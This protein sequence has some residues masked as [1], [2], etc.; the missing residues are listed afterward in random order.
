ME[1]TAALPV[2][3]LLDY[4]SCVV[5]DV[6]SRY[7]GVRGISMIIGE[8]AVPEIID[9]YLPTKLFIGVGHGLPCV[10]TVQGKAPYIS[11]ESNVELC[12][13]NRR[14]DS[15]RGS[16]VYLISCYTGQELGPELVNRGAAAFLGFDDEYLFY[17]GEPPCTEASRA[18]FEAEARAIEV[19]LR[20]GTVR[21][22]NEA[23]LQAYD[24]LADEWSLGA[25]AV[26]PDA[27]LIS[28]LLEYDKLI[29]TALG[30]L[31]YAPLKPIE[32]TVTVMREESPLVKALPIVLLLLVQR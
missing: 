18:V 7:S 3:D 24:E 32:G 17:I 29:L 20:G 25:K 4:P 21:E 9:Q 8:D 12:D 31:D 14:L 28:R 27:P 26:H 5:W 22:A 16:V 2:S 30:D 11:K 10:F 13:A 1:V 23:R 15:F 19:L 6:L